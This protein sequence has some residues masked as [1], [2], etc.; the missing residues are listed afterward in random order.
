MPE[1]SVVYRDASSFDFSNADT[2]RKTATL[3]KSNVETATQ[4]QQV[5]TVING[6]VETM[7]TAN[8]GDKII[9]GPKGERYVIRKE[10]FDS[11][12][13]QDPNNPNG[14]ISKQVIKA[15][16][17]TEDTEITA[18]WGEK[19]R[20]PK[21]SMV[22]QSVANPK[23]VYLIEEGAFKA[24]YTRAAT[25]HGAPRAGR[26]AGVAGLVAPLVVGA[27][28]AAGTLIGTGSVAAAK[29]AGEGAAADTGDALSLRRPEGRS[30]VGRWAAKAMDYVENVGNRLAGINTPPSG[31]TTL[32][33]EQQR[34]QVPMAG[35][36]RQPKTPAPGGGN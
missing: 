12:Y 5:E 15:Q 3:D 20:A 21:G 35:V 7:N 29:T 36:P 24:T 26:I 33:P 14:Y 27:A 34:A 1:T 4:T 18:P 19:Q 16:T 25:P 13:G 9:T 10:K 23:D 28:V 17:L 22:A 6:K 8:E 11:L 32:S 31:N 2:Y 30:G